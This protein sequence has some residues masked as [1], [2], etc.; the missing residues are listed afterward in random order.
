MASPGEQLA[1]ILTNALNQWAKDN[2]GL[3]TVNVTDTG[4]GS[5]SGGGGTTEDLVGIILGLIGIG[6]SL[7]PEV[8][9][10]VEGLKG[11]SSGLDSN[12]RSLAIAY[13]LAY[14]MLPFLEPFSRIITHAAEAS[15]TSQIFEP[16]DAAEL[17]ARQ[18]ITPAFGQSEAGGGGFD[19]THWAA[20]LDAAYIRPPWDV[21][22][23]LWNRGYIQETD[24]NTALQYGGIPQYWWA[25]LKALR[26][27]ILT[28]ADWALAALRGAVSETDAQA[29]AAE[30][31]LSADSFNTLMLNTGEPPGLMQLLEA[32]RRGFIDQPTLELGIRQ[33]RVRDQWIPTIEALRYVPM[34][35]ADAAN[36]VVRGYLDA[37]SGADIAQQN[38]LE[39]DHWQYVLESNGRPPSHEQLATLYLRGIISEADFEQGIRESDIKD[40]YITDVFDLRVKFLPLFEARTLLNDGDIT[41]ATFTEQMLVQGYQQ[42]VI[43]EILAA[44]GTGKKATAKHLS[45]A[46]YTDLYADGLKNRADTLTGLE[47]IGYTTDDATSI[48]DIADAKTTNAIV[49]QQ[50]A[51]VRT[52]FNRYKL[53]SDQA[54]TELSDIGL[55][56][57][58]ITQL[59][60][61]WTIT[62]PEGTR[63]LTEAQILKAAKDGAITTDDALNRLRGLGLDAV[64]AQL[65]VLISG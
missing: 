41:S 19:A 5:S 64:D 12:G 32:Y 47:S 22:L 13:F 63:T 6:L 36:A 56:A 24:V 4:G 21:A 59:V 8:D 53:T 50:V 29:G 18:I 15:V 44:V 57:A 1:T 17:A 14:Q 42:S 9:A 34:S 27:E 33:S 49:K 35:T 52:Q 55:V 3:F 43:D 65:L 40:K 37:A 26:E 46:D 2:P 54:T 25:S 48:V 61:A 62:R 10:V 23:R 31:G 38:G 51:N 20:M 60:N 28:P 16:D 45:A 30:W 58:Q 7:N 39:P 11:A